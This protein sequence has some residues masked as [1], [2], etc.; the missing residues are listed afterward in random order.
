MTLQEKEDTLFGEK[1]SKKPLLRL[2]VDY[3]G[4]HSAFAR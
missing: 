2:K 3:K 1:N 4:P